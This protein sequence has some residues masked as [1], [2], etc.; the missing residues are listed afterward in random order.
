MFR[1]KGHRGTS[2]TFIF[3]KHLIIQA[4][5]S[6]LHKGRSNI[7]ILPNTKPKRFKSC[8]KSRDTLNL[9]IYQTRFSRQ[10]SFQYFRFTEYKTKQ[11]HIMGHVQPSHLSNFVTM[12]TKISFLRRGHPNTLYLP[13]LKPNRSKYYVTHQGTLRDKF[14]LT[15]IKHVII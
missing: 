7:F 10:G 9:P 6:F 3:I 2:S 14:K 11:V 1:N 5:I 12:Q 8:F 4:K 13:N 15:F